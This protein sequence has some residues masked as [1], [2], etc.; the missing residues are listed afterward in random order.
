MKLRGKIN[1]PATVTAEGG[2]EIVKANGVW[3]LRPKWDDLAVETSL[4]DASNRRLWMYNPIIGSYS[5]LSVQALI[6]SLPA[7]PQGEAATIAVGTVTT[8]PFGSPATVTN[9][10]TPEE[11]IFDI[12]IPA[13]QNGAGDMSAANNLSDV[14]NKKT[15]KDNISLHG[16][17]IASAATVNLEAATGDLVDVTG[18]TTIT[19]ITLS[20]GHERTVRF[21]GALTLTHGASLVLPGAANIVTAADDMAV[22]RG[23]AAGVVRCVGFS[24][25]AGNLRADG[26][27]TITGGFKVVPFDLG[28]ITSFTI[29]PALGNYQY[30]T[31]NGAATWTAPASDCAI[32]ILITNGATAGSIT[33]SGFTVASGNTGDPLT[34]TNG[35]KF[36]VSIRRINAIST[37]VIKALQ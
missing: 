34:T 23:Y 17:D 27:Q 21:T 14:S 18:T 20:E 3:T 29:D 24:P 15:A 10:G 28:N 13:G 5:Q 16:S 36:I 8:V 33:F 30:G 4:P 7:G 26:K 6:D 9:I 25:I 1:F 37:Y 2:F 31:N 32:D 22:F 19:A 12:E 35:H 11:A